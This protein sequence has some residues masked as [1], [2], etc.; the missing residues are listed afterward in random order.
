MIT[1]SFLVILQD[2]PVQKMA[3]SCKI[4][5]QLMVQVQEMS[6]VQYQ[7]D[8][9][10]FQ[11]FQSIEFLTVDAAGFTQQR[12]HVHPTACLLVDMYS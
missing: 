7:Q 2:F 5:S 10:Q 11:K 6:L 3:V 1:L 4:L 8:S 9:L 12:S